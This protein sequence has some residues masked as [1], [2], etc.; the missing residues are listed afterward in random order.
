MTGTFGGALEARGIDASGGKLVSETEG[1]VELL[2]GVL[3]IKRIRIHYRLKDCPLDKREAAE[4]AH[5]A[6]PARCPVHQTI[7]ACVEMT[8]SLEYV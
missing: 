3:V 1:E 2:A 5:V 8:T 7:G 6:H 4:R